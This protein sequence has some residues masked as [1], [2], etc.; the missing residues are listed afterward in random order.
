MNVSS[1]KITAGVIYYVVNSE[2]SYNIGNAA[3]V[4]EC[5]PGVNHIVNGMIG[6]DYSSFHEF[7]Q[8]LVDNQL[9]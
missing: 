2:Q 3:M 5:M 9:F 1:E 7:L 8:I 4:V 6:F